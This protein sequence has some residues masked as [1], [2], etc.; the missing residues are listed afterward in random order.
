MP[1]SAI[2]II[3]AAL[4]MLLAG[5]VMRA[6]DGSW[7]TPA[8]LFALMWAAYSPTFLFFVDD[9]SPYIAGNMWILLSVVVV[10]LGASLATG[11][12]PHPEQLTKVPSPRAITAIKKLVLISFTAGLLDTIWLFIQRG[13]SIFTMFS[14]DALTM[15]SVL[16]RG[17]QYA[18]EADT[19]I[20]ERIAIALLYLGA[21]YG[22]MLFR[23]AD[24]R[25]DKW[26]GMSA[27]MML[28]LINTLHGS[29]FGS[30][31]GGGFWL[32]AYLST[33]VALSDPAKGV[34]SKFLFRFAA[35]GVLIVLGFSLVTM[36]IR[37]SMWTDPGEA[38]ISWW[39]IFSD[40]FGYGAAFGAWF[41]EPLLRST[42]PQLGARIFRRIAGIWGKEYPLYLPVDVGF[43]TSNV[44]TIFR[45][46]IDDF[47]LAGSLIF[48]LFYGF[49]AK[50][51]F[52]A[53]GLKNSRTAIP[54]LAIVYGFAFTGVASSAFGYTTITGAAVLFIVGA[55]F[56]PPITV[57]V[58]EEEPAQA[59][60]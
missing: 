28:I 14:L 24:Q 1:H 43:N 9:A 33:H 49:L 17:E 10:C 34:S 47:T 12:L 32:A 41:G 19:P 40:P 36:G 46:L 56:L 18:G 54:W 13:F 35:S 52:W 60:E 15:V 39:Y 55:N 37:Y 53:A 26:V 29:R 25:R 4:T 7:V 44:F 8:A 45:E 42:E 59:P 57:V 50:I 48:L 58:D 3:D 2:A 22:G 21:M 16:N 20:P 27:L 30:I 51:A 5:F 6:R 31:Y 11:L 23:L 38:K